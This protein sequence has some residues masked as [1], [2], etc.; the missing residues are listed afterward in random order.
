MIRVT[1]HVRGRAQFIVICVALEIHGIKQ[2]I[3]S[4]MPATKKRIA[5][6][7]KFYNEIITTPNIYVI[8]PHTAL[9]LGVE[10]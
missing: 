7:I 10:V 6:T 5:V 8:I 2:T 4:H 3:A 9:N 1:Q